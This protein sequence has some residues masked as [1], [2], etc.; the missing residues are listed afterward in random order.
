MKVCSDS[1]GPQRMN[2]NDSGDC[3]LWVG[4]VFHAS[5]KRVHV[6]LDLVHDMDKDFCCAEGGGCECT[7]FS[8]D[9]CSNYHPWSRALGS[10]RTNEAAN[11]G[12]RH[13]SLLC[14]KNAFYHVTMLLLACE[15]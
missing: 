9:M 12:G 11:T 13:E 3:F 6:S 8:V 1:S 5:G 10:D 7:A 4:S 15:I 14:I 2:T